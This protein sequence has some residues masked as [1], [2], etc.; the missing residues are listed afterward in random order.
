LVEKKP[1]S[2]KDGT[3]P[4][5][6][7]IWIDSIP[8]NVSAKESILEEHW[9]AIACYVKFRT[10]NAKYINEI[11]DD[12]NSGIKKAYKQLK[13]EGRLITALAIKQRYLGKDKVILTFKTL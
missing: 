10:K 9:C 3:I 13:D 6:A 12:I 1:Q 8:I 2:K 5:Y 7:R 4:I 11:L